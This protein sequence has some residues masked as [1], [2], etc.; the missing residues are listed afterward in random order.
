M[1]V[2]SCS[3][4]N[5]VTHS[6]ASETAYLRGGCVGESNV[7]VLNNLCL[8]NIRTLFILYIGIDKP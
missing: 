8:Q 3:K 2:C 5:H 4:W 1:Y 6:Q 7:N